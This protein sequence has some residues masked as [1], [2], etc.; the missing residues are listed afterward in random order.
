MKIYLIEHPE[1]GYLAGNSNSA[2]YFT[3]S[4]EFGRKFNRRS[5]ASNCLNTTCYVYRP[6]FNWRVIQKEC[7]VVCYTLEIINKDEF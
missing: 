3:K 7:K 1:L 2:K 5:D 4:I 6:I